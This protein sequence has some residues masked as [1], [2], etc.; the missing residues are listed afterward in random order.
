MCYADVMAEVASRA[1]R[2][3]TRAVLRRVQ[4]GEPVTITVDGIPVAQ[5]NPIPGRPTWMARSTF[6]ARVLP[7]QADA[8]LTDELA[9]LAPDTT[10]S[11]PL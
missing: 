3:D 9:R 2:N 1:L 10:D 8:A 6:A 11:L 7:H 5:L 4:D